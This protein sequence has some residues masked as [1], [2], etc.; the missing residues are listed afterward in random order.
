MVSPD[1]GQ[2][3]QAGSDLQPPAVPEGLAAMAVSS[4]QISLS[5]N[6]SIDNVGVEGYAIYRNGIRIA[7]TASAAYQDAGLT[8][9]TSCSYRVAAYD[10]AGNLSSLSSTVTATAFPA[11]SKAFKVGDRVQITAQV[12][13]RSAAAES[14]SVLGLQAK[15]ASG[16]VISGPMYWNSQWWWSIDFR[17]GMDGWVSEAKLKKTTRPVKATTLRRR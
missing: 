7:T 15:G 1:S 16:I 8:A 3:V 11:L 2:A 4:S 17:S 5:W 6:A 10:A 14:G 13:V 12:S 9:S